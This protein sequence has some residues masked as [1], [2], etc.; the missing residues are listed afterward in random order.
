M[1]DISI[2]IPMYNNFAG[3][4]KR[5]WEIHDNCQRHLDTIEILVCDDVSPKIDPV[6]V[7][8]KM[9]W[10][11]KKVFS[12]EGFKYFRN[13]I[14]YGFGGNC[15]LGVERAT[16]KTVTFL[17]S[18]VQIKGDF[19]FPIQKL[20]A[21]EGV[22]KLVG[23]RLLN[24]DT[25]WNVFDGRIFPYLEGWLLACKIEDFQKLG[26]FDYRY[27]KF[28]YEDVDLSTTALSMGFVLEALPEPLFSHW[29]GSSIIT[30]MGIEE[31]AEKTKLNRE[32][33]KKKWLS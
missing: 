25:G 7:D 17:S 8:K 6:E 31:R 28:D 20:L 16:G 14:N 10:W 30:L 15:N 27:G 19:V 32:V 23:G 5:L 26:G 33:F 13:R 12:E 21:E 22:S 2:I 11:E 3:V 1:R 24:F 9:R 29:N 4:E 18:D